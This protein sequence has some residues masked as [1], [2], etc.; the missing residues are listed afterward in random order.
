MSSFLCNKMAI[1]TGGSGTLGKAI[2]KSLLTAGCNVFI[3]GRNQGRLEAAAAELLVN[4]RNENSGYGKLETFRGDVLSETDVEALFD[5]AESMHGGVDLLVNNAG[6][7][8]PGPTHELSVDDF[9]YVMRVNVT[10][11]FI[12]ARAAVKKMRAGGKGGRII[13]IGSIS[14]ISP[15]PDSAPYTTSKFALAGLSQSL[16][17][18]YRRDNIA[19]G[20]IHPGNV[21]SNLLSEEEIEKREAAEGFISAET[22]AQ[23]VLSMSSLPYNSNVLEMTVMPTRQPLVGRG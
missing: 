20:I 9:D 8:V 10:G 18:D 19:V 3:T 22:V 21:A 11:P 6:V 15:R 16:A 23:C 14:A 4:S 12:C 5:K 17:L 7:A 1:V 2:A 13:N